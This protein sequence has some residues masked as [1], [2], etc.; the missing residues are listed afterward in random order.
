[1]Q[2]FLDAVTHWA[3]HRQCTLILRRT[4]NEWNAVV[5]LK[6]AYGSFEAIVRE[7]EPME[8]SEG[9]RLETPEE[10]RDRVYKLLRNA[11]LKA[12]KDRIGVQFTKLAA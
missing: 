8:T 10:F 11:V 5:L 6:D 9:K 7:Q 3:D 4:K 12:R 2:S 1:M